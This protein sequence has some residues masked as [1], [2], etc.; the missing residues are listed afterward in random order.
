MAIGMACGGVKVLM[1]KEWNGTYHDN[2]GMRK[3][4]MI[5]MIV[6]LDD[7]KPTMTI[8]GMS[9]VSPPSS[10]SHQTSTVPVLLHDH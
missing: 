4:I 1:I 6:H 10:K 2:A 5:I 7:I 3:V 9:R 8:W